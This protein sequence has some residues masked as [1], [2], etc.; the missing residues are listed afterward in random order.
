M[1]T[2]RLLEDSPADGAA[3]LA[4]DEAILERAVAAPVDPTLRLYGWD[5]PTLSLGAKQPAAG[6]HDL[7]WLLDHGIGLVRRPTGGRAVLHEHERTYAVVARLDAAPFDGGVIATYAAIAAALVCAV[8]RL[9]L[10]ARAGGGEPDPGPAGNPVCFARPGALEIEVD[11]R[12][13]VGSAQLRR[14]GAFLQHGSILLRADAARWS[15]AIGS[16]ADPAAFA[17]IADL[18]GRDVG[19]D[20]VDAA[21]LDGFEERLGARFRR[22]PVGESEQLRAAELRCWKYD[23]G[24]W[25]LDGRVGEREVRWGGDFRIDN[26]NGAA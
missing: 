3:N 21:V 22:A 23:S 14:R 2:W 6:S 12:K 9:G 19:A 26:R 4:L 17:G 1:T 13:V 24:A 8:E 10:P 25:T 5:P 11:G 20:E 7:D 18:L 15:A 16:A